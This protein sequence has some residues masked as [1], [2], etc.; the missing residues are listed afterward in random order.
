MLKVNKKFEVRRALKFLDCNNFQIRQLQGKVSLS[1]D[2][3]C[4]NQVRSYD[5]DGYLAGLLLPKNIQPVFFAI[6]AFNIE[7][8]TI[9]DNVRG[10]AI[11]GRIR[12]QWWE[13]TLDS[14]FSN[15][16]QMQQ[17]NRKSFQHPVADAIQH[18][19]LQNS[20]SYMWFAG[21]LAAR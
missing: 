6:R 15:H 20:L 7:I 5:Y 8:A 21:T 3:Y 10:N 4:M 2:S 13:D 14:I 12:F 9:K 18:H 1:F 11:A 19:A 16:N 17:Q